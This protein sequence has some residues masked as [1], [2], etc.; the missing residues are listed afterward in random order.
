MYLYFE[1]HHDY[2]KGYHKIHYKNTQILNKCN[3]YFNS[4]GVTG[5]G[6]QLNGKIYYQNWVNLNVYKSNF[7]HKHIDILL[8]SYLRLEKIKKIIK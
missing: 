7:F 4:L 8:K 1:E 5:F 6:I 2:S 3:K